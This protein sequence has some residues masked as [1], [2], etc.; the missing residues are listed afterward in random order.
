MEVASKK[1]AGV[2]RGGLPSPEL[3]RWKFVSLD[4]GYSKVEAERD[5]VV[6][7]LEEEY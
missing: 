5:L 2:L 1:S 4:L 6:G 7:S 3:F